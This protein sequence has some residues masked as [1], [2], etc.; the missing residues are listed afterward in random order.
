MR[1]VNMAPVDPD[2]VALPKPNAVASSREFDSF[3]A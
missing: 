3:E 2:I 1:M